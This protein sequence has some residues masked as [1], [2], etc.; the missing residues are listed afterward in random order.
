MGACAAIFIVLQ[1]HDIQVYIRRSRHISYAIITAQSAPM[2]E[3]N[4]SDADGQ[5]TFSYN[6]TSTDLGSLPSAPSSQA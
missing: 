1:Q 4:V 3:L 5:I 2:A 6:G